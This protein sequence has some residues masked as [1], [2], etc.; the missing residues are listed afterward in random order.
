MV[1]LTREPQ[2]ESQKGAQEKL[3]KMLLEEYLEEKGYHLRDLRTLPKEQASQL[4]R[5]ATRYAS[6]KLAQM[7]S[8]AHFRDSIRGPS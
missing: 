4:M 8:S 2:T 1:S 7:E 3:E 6:L 5:E